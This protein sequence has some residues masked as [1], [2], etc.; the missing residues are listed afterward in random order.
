MYDIVVIGQGLTGLLSAIY[1][2]DSYKSV[3]LVSTGTGKIIQST[4]VMDVIPGGKEERGL[5]IQLHGEQQVNQMK[6][7]LNKFRELMRKLDY[8]Y[9]GTM[10]HSS[11]ILTGAG[12]IKETSLYPQTIYPI[13][14]SGKV[15]I[16]GFSELLDFQ[17]R[18]MMENLKKYRPHL[19]VEA[20]QIATGK[21][22]LRTLTQ[23]DIARLMERTE[24]RQ[25]IIQQIKE[26]VVT[27]NADMYI[28]PS[29]LGIEGWR[30]VKEHLEI[31]LNGMVSETVGMPP[32]ATAIRLYQLL[33]REAT[34]K[35]VRF[36]N[37][38][39][40]E[41]VDIVDGQVSTLFV[42]NHTKTIPLHAKSYI[43]ATG[44]VLGGGL[45]IT[46]SGYVDR[47]LG[48]LVNEYGSFVHT[49]SNVYPVGASEGMHKT[50][51]GITGGIYSILASYD[52]INQIQNQKERGIVYA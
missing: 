13:P 32:N 4:G 49:P 7:A 47:S 38:T 24:I 6:E 1:A 30:E 34:Q 3:A 2:K 42:N 48:L 51:H 52:V 25:D 8:P 36:F 45:E 28:F 19:H 33:K 44:G 16:V 40:T 17:P 5:F 31:D 35:G 14:T 43:V 15:V 20:I 29:C 27:T 21:H 39:T 10:Y 37:N 18:Y 22:S 50:I 11:D 26:K 9:E 46:H 23:L 41:R 12:H